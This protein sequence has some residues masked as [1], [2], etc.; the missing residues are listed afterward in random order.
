MKLKLV[1]SHCHLQLPAY[2]L[3]RESVLKGARAEGIGMIAV[4]TNFATSAAAVALAEANPEGVW[5]TIAVHPG[6]VHHPHHDASETVAS[7]EAEFLIAVFL[8]NWPL[9]PKSWPLAKPAL[10]IIAWRRTKPCHLSK[11]KSGKK[12]IL[13]PTSRLPK[14]KICPSLCTCATP[15]TMPMKY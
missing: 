4:G 2:D 11:S 9:L 5:A 1:D 3:D 14:P 7:P 8:K 10:I 6:H 13:S 15:M 12:K